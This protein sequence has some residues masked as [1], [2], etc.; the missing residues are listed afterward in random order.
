[1]VFYD[2][3]TLNK[4]TKKKYSLSFEVSHVLH[5][6]GICIM[7]WFQLSQTVLNKYIDDRS[8]A[9]CEY[10]EKQSRSVQNNAKSKQLVGHHIFLFSFHRYFCL[11]RSAQKKPISAGNLYIKQTLYQLRIHST[12]IIQYMY[13]QP[14][15]TDMIVYYTI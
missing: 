11:N 6:G 14:P 12:P 3:K 9:H 10:Y 13:I 7:L 15:R 8:N 5:F 1:M 4:Q 2:V